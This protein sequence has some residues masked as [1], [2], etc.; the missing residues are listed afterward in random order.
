MNQVT[1]YVDL[2]S[3][4]RITLLPGQEFPIAPS[5]VFPDVYHGAEQLSTTSEMA[6]LRKACLL[7][8]AP[9]HVSGSLCSADSAEVMPFRHA[10]LP[11]ALLL[12]LLEYCEEILKLSHVKVNC[13]WTLPL[14]L[15]YLYFSGA[16]SGLESPETGLISGSCYLQL[17]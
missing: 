13:A 8:K 1:R 6:L 14:S 12:P 7:I 5:I 10:I 11:I 15:H 16:V 9:A 2:L 3:L 17:S 4:E